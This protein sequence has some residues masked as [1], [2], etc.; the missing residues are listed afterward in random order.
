M[1]DEDLFEESIRIARDWKRRALAAEKDIAEW[2]ALSDRLD[3][4]VNRARVSRL[5]RN[6]AVAG[7]LYAAAQRG[8]DEALTEVERLRAVLETIGLNPN[9]SIDDLVRSAETLRAEHQEVCAGRSELAGKLIEAVDENIRIRLYGQKMH[10]RAQVAERDVR[11]ARRALNI[12][13]AANMYLSEEVERLRAEVAS[14]KTWH[15]KKPYHLP[16]LECNEC[17]FNYDGIKCRHPEVGE[18]THPYYHSTEAY[19]EEDQKP[20]WCPLEKVSVLV[21][22]HMSKEEVELLEITDQDGDE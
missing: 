22:P 6:L 4:A 17:P 1:R 15:E 9:A 13:N 7:A 16:V 10:R 20:D 19:V 5:G 18:H 11:H 2:C 3:T 12:Q 14:R 21:R 8:C